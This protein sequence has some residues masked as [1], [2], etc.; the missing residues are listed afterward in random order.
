MYIN[1]STRTRILFMFGL[2]LIAVIAKLVE[3]SAVQFPARLSA[4]AEVCYFAICIIAVVYVERSIVNRM[5]RIQTIAVI[6]MTLL[7]QVIR[8]FEISATPM[9]SHLEMHLWYSYYYPTTLIPNLLFLATKNARLH[10]SQKIDNKWYLTL[11]V[12]LVLA[13]LVQFNDYHYWAFSFPLGDQLFHLKFTVGPL[14]FIAMGWVFLLIF[15]IAYELYFSAPNSR[16]KKYRWVIIL[17]VLLVGGYLTWFVLIA[18]GGMDGGIVRA[19]LADP[20]IWMVFVLV[21][22]E[23]A[24]RLGFIRSNSNYDELYMASTIPNAIMDSNFNVIYRSTVSAVSTPEQREKAIEKSAYIDDDRR[25]HGQ[26]ISGG[27]SYWIE[28]LSAINSG[29]RELSIVREVLRQDNDLI[30]A[31][32]DM[33]ERR[34]KTEEKMKLYGMLSKNVEPQLKEIDALIHSCDPSSPAF[35]SYL[36]RACVY[37]AYIKRLSNLILLGN[38]DDN[39]NSFELQSSLRESIEYLKLNDIDCNLISSGMAEFPSERMVLAYSI[40]QDI[41][42]TNL[43][44][45]KRVLVKFD[46]GEDRFNLGILVTSKGESG[47]RLEKINEYTKQVEEYGGSLIYNTRGESVYIDMEI[48]KKGGPKDAGISIW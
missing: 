26:K 34:T 10:D 6:V 39:L 27:Y 21:E 8:L 41:V 15:G 36:K 29:A 44:W 16:I 7:W 48:P 2:F 30:K 37:K 28:D 17:Y 3:F 11:I 45:L 47:E 40:Y 14:Y 35:K 38:Q 1:R 42:E 12:S 19:V 23:L 5:A 9:D 43:E 24:I 20:E 13:T 32:N 4:F 46:V 22:I 33:I 31:E 25:L 18:N